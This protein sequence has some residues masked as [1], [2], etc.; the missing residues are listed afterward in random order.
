MNLET[1]AT[2]M[3]EQCLAANDDE[4]AFH[5]VQRRLGPGLILDLEL[6][7]NR[8][9]LS[10]SRINIRP[11]EA[12]IDTCTGAFDAPDGTRTLRGVAHTPAVKPIH[13]A[14]LQW[15]RQLSFTEEE[16]TND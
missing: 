14:R 2:E 12:E 10:L 11:S 15:L 1:I 7:A 8:W 4:A 9:Q 5:I 6:S 16:R 3:K 13:I